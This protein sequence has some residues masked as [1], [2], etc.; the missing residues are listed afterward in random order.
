MSK[1]K[2]V[3]ESNFAVSEQFDQRQQ[4]I[5]IDRDL[6]HIFLYVADL[7][8]TPYGSMYGNEI[9]QLVT[10]STAGTYYMVG[11]S[12]ADGGS[13]VDFT[14]Q[15]AKELKCNST[16]K[17]LA[18]YSMSLDCGTN[19]QD[20]SGCIMVNATAQL[21]TTS[22]NFNGQ[23]SSKNSVVAGTGILSLVKNDLVRL[24]VTNHTAAN[25]ITVE[26]ANLTLSMLTK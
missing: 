16:A 19:S 26:H 23:G 13:S 6:S 1:Q 3:K 18:T 2:P 11:G 12:L 25:N 22:H 20:L 14:F 7:P 15:N 5:M 9:S 21:N 4:F 24:A 10:V 8:N 17:Y